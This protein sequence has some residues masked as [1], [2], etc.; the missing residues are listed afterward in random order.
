VTDLVF[1]ADVHLVEGDEEAPVFMRFL[2]SLAGNSSRCIIVGDL[3]NVWI[4]RRR[5]MGPGQLRLLEV[6]GEVATGGV[7]FE[8][9]EGNRDYFVGENWR[10]DAFAEVA[11]GSMTASAGPSR[12]LVTHGDQVN[13]ADIPY[14]LWRAVSRSLP[15]RVLLS[16]LPGRAGRRLAHSL[17]RR[18]RGTNRRHKAALPMAQLDALTRQATAGGCQGVVLGH[19]HTEL[20]RQVGEGTLWILPDWRSGRRYLRF[21]QD[22]RGRFVSYDAGMR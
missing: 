10:G 21:G 22:G 6:I 14:R 1:V 11:A 7:R 18:L 12:L 16:L 13:K 5:F 9:V 19:F 15:V 17:E 8:Y 20:Q 4:A 3:F 2:R